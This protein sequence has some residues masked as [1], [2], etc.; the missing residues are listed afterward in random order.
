MHVV[1]L[2]VNEI[3]SDTRVKRQALSLARAGFRTTVLARAAAAGADVRAVGNVIAVGVEVPFEVQT[4]VLGLRRGRRAWRPLPGWLSDERARDLYERRRRWRERA[5]AL[6]PHGGDP[7]VRA[8]R[9]ARRLAARSVVDGARRVDRGMTQL[10]TAFD[11]GFQATSLGASW[12][13]T[14]DGLVDDLELV[15]GPVLD[16]LAPDVIHAH[17]M[18]VLGVAVHAA[19]RA[20]KAGRD[21]KVVYDAHEYVAGLAVAGSFTPRSIAAWA[22]LEAEF[23]PVA[24]RVIAVSPRSAAAIQERL[25][26]HRRPDVVHNVPVVGPDTPEDVGLRRVC[27]LADDVPLVVYSGGIREVRGIDT[28]IDALQHLPGVHLAVVCVPHPRSRPVARLRAHARSR[29]VHDRVHFV[30]PVPPHQVVPYLSSADVGLI[31]MQGGWRNHELTL[32]N[33]LFEYI[34]AG[35]PLVVSELESLGAF[36]REHHVGET[37]P[38]GDAAALARSVRTVLEDG[39]RYRAA[40]RA[41]AVARVASWREQERVLHR[42]YAEMLGVDELRPVG[43]RAGVSLVERPIRRRG[44][45]AG[46]QPR[47]A[48]GPLNRHGQAAALA[49]A[50]RSFSEVEA[51]S[52]VVVSRG[53]PRADVVVPRAR[54]EGDLAWRAG[55]LRR[56]LQDVTHVLSEDGLALA[57][58]VR[59]GDDGDSEAQMLT[60]AGV[61]LGFLVTADLGSDAADRLA[62]WRDEFGASVFVPEH[63]ALEQVPGAVWL[64]RVVDVP[65][66]GGPAWHGERRPVVAAPSAGVGTTELLTALHGQG[67]LTYEPRSATPDVL[68]MDHD[69]ADLSHDVLRAMARGAVVVG[70]TGGIAPVLR[71]S[72]ADFPAVLDRILTDPESA[73]PLAQEGLAY[74]REVHD[75]RRSASVLAAF[76]GVASPHPTREA[77]T[78]GWA[79]ATADGGDR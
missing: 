30:D 7:G 50:L 51:E 18:H 52:L 76:L 36:V 17:D 58:G 6:G 49:A 77:A 32:P 21:V 38:P 65:L 11:E 3:T 61:R 14:L 60:D 26:L 63:T 55:R 31:P 72:P 56:L 20:R 53:R 25:G 4:F 40:T 67:R 24:D 57:G 69:A 74:V 46:E 73:L 71:A 41:P 54:Y 64:P 75:G 19:Q 23:A 35:V 79:A 66:A 1:T 34:V 12:R 9:L 15:L 39:S 2:T 47:V 62:R 43:D 68:V 22:D 45:E 78:L 28:A 29:G 37:F 5:D 70:P 10:W 48:V 27:E 8:R 13:W 59:G 44:L 33:K 16:S 42:A